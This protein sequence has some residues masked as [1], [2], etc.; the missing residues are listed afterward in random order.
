M[1]ARRRNTAPSEQYYVEI[2]FLHKGVFRKAFELGDKNSN[3][4][5][6]A[7]LFSYIDPNGVPKTGCLWHEDNGT[8]KFVRS[9]K[10][11]FREDSWHPSTAW[12]FDG[13]MTLKDTDRSLDVYGTHWC[14]IPD[15]RGIL[16]LVYQDEDELSD[17]PRMYYTTYDST[18]WS[19]PVMGVTEPGAYC[20]LA[21]N[22]RKLYWINSQTNGGTGQR[23]VYK[24]MRLG[25][26]QSWSDWKPLSPTPTGYWQGKLRMSCIETFDNNIPIIFMKTG[27]GELDIYYCLLKTNLYFLP[28]K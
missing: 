4:Q 23:V 9:K 27:S 12:E 6:N 13:N 15:D 18:S 17:D 16:H 8:T 20:A 10:F 7:K 22:G 25:D 5:K 26:P 2:Y 11:A 28:W 19:T 21:Q 24:S 3:T 14:I 1:A